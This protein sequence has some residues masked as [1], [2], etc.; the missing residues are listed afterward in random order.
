ML[1]NCCYIFIASPRWQSYANGELLDLISLVV[2]VSIGFILLMALAAGGLALALSV[3]FLI[4]SLFE[5]SAPGIQFGKRMLRLSST[6]R[7]ETLKLRTKQP[8]PA[9]EEEKG[10]CA[11][12]N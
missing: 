8:R 6:G 5:G 11:E 2:I 3:V 1:L 9:W 7:S 12:R 4:R 10:E